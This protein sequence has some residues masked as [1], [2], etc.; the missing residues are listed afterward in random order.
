MK[1]DLH[2]LRIDK[3][4]KSNPGG[5]D[6]FWFLVSCAL[7]LALVGLGAYLFLGK[8]Q[9][10]AVPGPDEAAAAAEPA[11]ESVPVEEPQADREVL[12]ASGYVVAHHKHELGSKVMG[13]VEWIGVEKG[14]LV[15]K[16]QLLVKL[17]DR[18]FR[19]QLEQAQASLR[20][21]RERLAELEAGSRPQEIDRAEADVNRA[22]A[23]LERRGIAVPISGGSPVG[24]DPTGT[25]RSRTVERCG[26][27]CADPA[28]RDR[29]PGSHQRHRLAKDR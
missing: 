16:G 25:G 6:R 14:D 20:A 24:D 21:A 5:G 23:E 29:N 1:Q 3:D 22:R 19:A 2:A 4:K 26:Q 10:G 17:E 28:G 15:K 8:D 11:R 9:I 27:L 18:E 13:R 12:I 7:L